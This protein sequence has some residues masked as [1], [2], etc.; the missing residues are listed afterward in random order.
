MILRIRIVF[1][2]LPWS[3]MN[4]VGVATG[5]KSTPAP[6]YVATVPSVEWIMVRLSAASS[7]TGM[8]LLV[9]VP[10]F[11]VRV[12]RAMFASFLGPSGALVVAPL[13]QREGSVGD[14]RVEPELPEAHLRVVR[15]RV[16]VDRLD[17]HRDRVRGHGPRG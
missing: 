15:G 10:S 14:V 6:Q 3:R 8:V 11:T 12:E 16:G 9:P 7:T 1:D 17:L 4:A 5:T 2:A 13:D